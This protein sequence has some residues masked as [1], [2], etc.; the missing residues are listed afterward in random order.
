MTS[1]R[2]QNVA[3]IFLEPGHATTCT[4]NGAVVGRRF[5][6]AAVDG[7]PSRPSVSA[8][9]AG[10]V[11]YGVAH[12]DAPTGEPVSVLRQGTVGVEA[13]EALTAGMII[14]T[15]ASGKAVELAASAPAV[16][17]VADADSGKTAPITLL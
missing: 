16:G 9:T 12:Y 3:P 6:V 7:A 14:A 10:K 8:G 5:V 2:K 15:G 1:V 13:G 17:S 4:A 11:A